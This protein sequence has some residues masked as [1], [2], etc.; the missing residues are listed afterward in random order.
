MPKAALCIAGAATAALVS[1]GCDVPALAMESMLVTLVCHTAQVTC[2]VWKHRV[3]DKLFQVINT[4]L[5]LC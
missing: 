4:I 2:W 1:S 5:R 3:L